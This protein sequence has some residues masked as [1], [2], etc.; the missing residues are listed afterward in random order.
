MSAPDESSGAVYAQHL[1]FE[2][3]TDEQIVERVRHALV[4]A[5]KQPDG[6]TFVLNVR[7]R[8]GRPERVVQLDLMMDQDASFASLQRAAHMA[9]SSKMPRAE[10]ALA[11]VLTGIES[12][13]P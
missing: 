10:E 12:G 6:L 3:L 5:R 11:A 1:A 7:L 4:F 13:Q 8:R 2:E 9:V